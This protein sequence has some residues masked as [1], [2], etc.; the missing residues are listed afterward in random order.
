[1]NATRLAVLGFLA[2]SAVAGCTSTPN[3]RT[4]VV[5]VD[6]LVRRVS[7]LPANT[8]QPLDL[9]VR[10]RAPAAVIAAGKAEPGKVALFVHG[11]YSPST[12]A[13]DVQ[14]RDYSWMEALAKAGYDVFAMDMTGYGRSSRPMMDEAC[15]LNPAQQKYLIGKPLAAECQP[16]YPYQLVSSDT[17]TADIDAVVDS[18]RKLR[19]V[20]KIALIGWSGGG[21][22]TGTY[23]VRHPDKVDK[24]IIQ[25]S[26]NYSRSNPD[27]KP[28]LPRAGFPMT[29]QFRDVGE[30]RRWLGTQ[31]CDGMI[32]PGMPDM[33]WK[34]NIDADPIGAT[35]GTGGLRAPTRT[36]W[37]WNANSAKKITVPTLIMVGEE[38]DLRTSNAQLFEDL[39]SSQKAFLAIACATHFAVWE[40]Q[41]RVLQRASLE[42]LRSTTLNGQRTGTFRADEGGRI[43]PAPLPAMTARADAATGRTAP[44]D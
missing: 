16:R 9:F 5:T 17:E 13:F 14:Y 43:G 42:W 30:G 8:G 3:E 19:G 12:L 40:A 22:R 44:A 33:I 15:N 31:K 20:D 34:M 2:C 23:T 39:G 1:M 24:L 27:A 4:D 21:I 6:R 41:H 32:E 36:Y 25:A 29:I 35:W 11:G 26:S 7:D 38:D 18:I 37:G 28:T 10:E